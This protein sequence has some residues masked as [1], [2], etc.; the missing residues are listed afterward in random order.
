MQEA[1]LIQ[2]PWNPENAS[3]DQRQKASDGGGC[4]KNVKDNDG[5]VKRCP[6]Q[7]T[8]GFLCSNTS[9]LIQLCQKVNSSRTCKRNWEH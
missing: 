1:C 6:E 5:G 4:E 9:S 7:R 2:K 3:N 8:Q